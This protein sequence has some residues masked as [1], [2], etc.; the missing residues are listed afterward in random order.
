MITPSP[1]GREFKSDRHRHKFL[2]R[3]WFLLSM[4]GNR[5]NAAPTS[6]ILARSPGIFRD[7]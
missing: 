7:D 6:G 2:I 1:C 5:E 4:N 3:V